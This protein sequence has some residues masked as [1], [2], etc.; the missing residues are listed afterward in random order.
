[1]NDYDKILRTV[2]QCG[3]IVDR[4]SNH[5][6]IRHPETGALVVTVPKTASDYRSLQNTKAEL[7]RNGCLQTFGVVKRAV[8]AA[9][10]GWLDTATTK[11]HVPYQLP[12][13]PPLIESNGHLLPDPEVE[14]EVEDCRVPLPVR[15]K[16]ANRGGRG[17]P[18]KWTAETM[19][20]AF[21]L[22]FMLGAPDQAP[23]RF[24]HWRNDGHIVRLDG[25]AWD[26]ADLFPSA[27]AMAAVYSGGWEQIRGYSLQ[28][29]ADEEADDD[30]DQF[31]DEFY[32]EEEEEEDR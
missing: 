4:T 11:P 1:M 2:K 31:D 8:E 14:P 26:K 20:E 3:W 16:E 5:I 23:S 19:T 24:D 7:R 10:A 9:E 6:K 30:L 13:P 32:G 25:M 12:A 22:A 29:I 21:A 28:I 15:I 18:Q 27:Q 17:R